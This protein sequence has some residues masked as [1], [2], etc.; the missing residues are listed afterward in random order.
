MPS[1]GK[2][3]RVNLHVLCQGTSE[4]SLSTLSLLFSSPEASLTLKR[5]VNILASFAELK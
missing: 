4:T 3:L 5:E 2:D 1:L